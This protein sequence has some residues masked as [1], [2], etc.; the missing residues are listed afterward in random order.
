MPLSR[1]PRV[2]LPNIDLMVELLIRGAGLFSGVNGEYR[3]LFCLAAPIARRRNWT[4]TV[5]AFPVPL[6]NLQRS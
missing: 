4:S 6:P 5:R 3:P 1:I 2:V